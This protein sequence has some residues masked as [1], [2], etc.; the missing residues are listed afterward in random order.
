MTLGP[1]VDPLAAH[2]GG[3]YAPAR[4]LAAPLIGALRWLVERDR[5][6]LLRGPRGLEGARVLEIGS[7]D[8]ALLELA[9]GAGA[10]RVLGIEPTAERRDA[11]DGVEVLPMRVEDVDLNH[12]A[13]GREA[14][15]L[16][17]CW[18]S[19]EHLPDPD[20][21]LQR[22]S[23]WL[24]P[25]GRVVVAVP[26]RAGLQARIGG[27]RWFHQDVPRHRSHYSSR[28]IRLA[29]ERQGLTVER[30]DH[31]VLDG[32]P[33]GMWQT[34]LNRLTRQPNFAF[35]LLKRDPTLELDSRDLIVTAT[36]G[37][38]L[39]PVAVAVEALAGIA[40]RGGTIVVRA[41]KR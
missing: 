5:L 26:D 15:D 4:G 25:G 20:A 41:R 12:E 37:P 9:R 35:R 21:A 29:L 14:F 40:R 28:G 7:G 8:G 32:G 11:P 31:L 30:S 16:V 2:S 13:G 6:R 1:V 10:A 34:L 36:L 24:A 27:D 23:R 22:T 33:L 17:V 19:L 38:A 3:V 18:H 39:I